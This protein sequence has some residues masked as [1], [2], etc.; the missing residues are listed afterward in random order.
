MRKQIQIMVETGNGP[1]PITK[2]VILANRRIRVYTIGWLRYMTH[3]ADV[4][5]RGWER[6]GILP[7]PICKL[8]G[9]TRWYSSAELLVYTALI[10]QHY[11]SGRDMNKLKRNLAE[12][13]IKIRKQYMGSVQKLP[14][15]MLALQNE[16]ELQN[17]FDRTRF[18][19][20]LSK[21]KFYEVDQIIQGIC[22]DNQAAGNPTPHSDGS[23]VEQL[24][25]GG[26]DLRNRDTVRQQPQSNSARQRAGGS[27]R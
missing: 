7:K 27:V 11:Q 14:P 16:K 1:K 24:P 15:E 5:L 20:K 17:S 13:N 21:E 2:D 8:A 6:N 3:L 18:K 12:A 9:N 4:T 26:G 22:Q 25:V 10:R 19:D 23:P